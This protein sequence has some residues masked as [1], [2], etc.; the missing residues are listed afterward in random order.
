[1]RWK[2]L[3]AAVAPTPHQMGHT[4][5]AVLCT[6]APVTAA[7]SQPYFCLLLCLPQFLRDREGTLDMIIEFLGQ[8]PKLKRS[9]E[10]S[11]F[12]PTP[13]GVIVA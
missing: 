1:M 13:W 4:L 5:A 8:D 9:P 3:T 2:A 11:N 10:V 6:A 7:V 12:L